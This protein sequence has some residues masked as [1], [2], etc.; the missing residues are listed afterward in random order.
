MAETTAIN[1]DAGKVCQQVIQNQLT[2]YEEARQTLIKM[3]EWDTTDEEKKISE[4]ILKEHDEET[5]K[6][7]TEGQKECSDDF[8]RDPETVRCWASAL[9]KW[10]LLNCI[11]SKG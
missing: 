11:P 4:E 1:E 6:L 10:D 7:K 5:K 3:S 8:K 9:D 2:Y